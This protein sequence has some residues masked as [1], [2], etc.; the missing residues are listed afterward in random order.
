MISRDTFE[1]KLDEKDINQYTFNVIPDRDPMPMIDDR[2]QN[3]QRISCTAGANDPSSCHKITRTICELLYTCGTGTGTQMR[4]ALC[5]CHDT[6]GYPKPTP[7][8]NRTYE[9]ACKK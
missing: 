8:G 9:E 3:F 6:Y 2:P 5:I 4:P 1:P 7:M